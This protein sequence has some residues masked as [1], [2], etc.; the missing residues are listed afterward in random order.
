MRRAMHILAPVSDSL[1]RA[2]QRMFN[3]VKDNSLCPMDPYFA[4]LVPVPLAT[5]TAWAFV[6]R[7]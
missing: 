1:L 7:S 5:Y 4:S 6:L 3:P 2:G